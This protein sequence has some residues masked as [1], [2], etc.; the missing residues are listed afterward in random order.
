MASS[1]G[2]NQTPT[3]AAKQSHHRYNS[4]SPHRMR[5]PDGEAGRPA[6]TAALS[7]CLTYSYTS[8]QI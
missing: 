2:C 8:G 1:A 7:P 5:G 3:D 4:L 6:D